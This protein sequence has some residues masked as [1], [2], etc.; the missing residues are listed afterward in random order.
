M[1]QQT[2]DPTQQA[3]AGVAPVNSPAEREADQ[4]AESVVT[5]GPTR[6]PESSTAGLHRQPVPGKEGWPGNTG[7]NKGKAV[8]KGIDRIPLSGLSVGHQAGKGDSGQ[9]IV[10]CSPTLDTSK[11]IDVLLHFHGHNVG[12]AETGKTARDDAIDRS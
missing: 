7:L 3:G 11:P 8:V 10:L 2:A 1:V 5:V 6:S 12:H 4:A 9:A